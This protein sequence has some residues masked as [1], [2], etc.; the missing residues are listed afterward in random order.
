MQGRIDI[1]FANAGI[2]EKGTLLPVEGEEEPIK[3]E[4][5]TA[6]V[7]FWGCLYSMPSLSFFK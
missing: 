6:E 4:T 7:N 5:K 3:P 1:V 2:T